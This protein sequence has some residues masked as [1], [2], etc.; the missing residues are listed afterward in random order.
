M[1]IIVAAFVFFVLAVLATEITFRWKTWQA[2]K[3]F[4]K[5]VEE[6]KE[7]IRQPY[8]NQKDNQ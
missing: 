2:K 4:E 3:R 6:A 5:W 7:D 8:Q 1:S